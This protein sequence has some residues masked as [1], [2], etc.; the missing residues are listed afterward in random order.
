MSGLVN[1]WI[2]TLQ[3]ESIARFKYRADAN[4]FKR[5]LTRIKRKYS[6]NRENRELVSIVSVDGINGEDKRED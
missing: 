6:N 3:G 1:K 4:L 5:A 2:V